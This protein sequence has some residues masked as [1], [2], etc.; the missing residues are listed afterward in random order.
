MNGN[1][2][3]TRR[4]F[5]KKSGLILGGGLV[6]SSLPS[7]MSGESS[8]TT[9]LGNN[10][11]K[12][13]SSWDV[14]VV[15]G[16]PGGCAAAVSAAREGAKTLIIE[17]TGQLGGMGT[18]GMVPAFTPFSD[19][20]KM[21][22]RGIA[23]KV[24]NENKKG[25]PHEP[26]EKLDWVSINPEHLMT[27][28]DN[29]VEESGTQVLFFSRVA[30]VEKSA[31]D[32]VDA[33]VVANNTGLTAFKAKVFIDAT[34]DGV[35]AFWSGAEA[36][37]GDELG[38][39]QA[40]TLCFAI[41]NVDMK[42][43]WKSGNLSTDNP[44]S[45][46]HKVIAS[47]KYEHVVRHMCLNPM[48]PSVI[49]FNAGHIDLDTTDPWQVS[50]AMS[51]GRQ[52]AGEYLCAL[53]DIAPQAFGNAFIVKTAPALGVRDSRR[54]V[55]DYILT[56]DDWIER[57]TF[58]D[59]IG[60]NCYWIDCHTADHV[61]MYYGKG[62]SHGIPYRV[63]TPKGLRN[64]LT[65]GRCVSTDSKIFGSMR[66]MP[67]CLVTGEAAG[68]AAAHAIRQSG[69][70]DVHTVDTDYLRRRLREEGQYFL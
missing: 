42:S 3:S 40:S 27:V 63:L 1:E 38:R 41:A 46:I 22:Y 58:D 64:V 39:L 49:E 51:L 61:P 14:I 2:M 44:D 20:E 31:D 48:G 19:G 29:M 12:V 37:K 35:L 69:R 13:D 11:I 4:D 68:M 52:I 8:G 25:V 32:T 60:R 23:E 62:D 34:G 57:R 9:R 50:K 6:A 30:A 59:E 47:K 15:G 21:I 54:I 36:H 66:I 17:A 5:L 24:F 18:I 10:R 43:Y 70:P 67:A 26:K 53:K 33:V 56:Q 16:G 55:G 65:A 45:P 28:Y 7:C